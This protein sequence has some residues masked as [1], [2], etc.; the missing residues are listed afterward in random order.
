MPNSPRSPGL[1]SAAN[2]MPRFT[3]SGTADL[4]DFLDEDNMASDSASAVASQQSIKAYA[5]LML[6]LAGGTLSGT[7][8]LADQLVT[9]PKL[10]GYG[11]TVNAIGSIGG[12]TQDIDFES[13]NVVT[14]TVDTSTTT[15]TFS[16]PPASG[17]AA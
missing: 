7:L 10:Q 6:P 17:T 3:G 15:F 4:V 14:G 16:N 1:T 5:D 2:K 12:G 11:E 9:R 8:A 13:G